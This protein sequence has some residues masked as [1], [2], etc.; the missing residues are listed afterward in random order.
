MGFK[1]V[2]P[3]VPKKGTPRAVVSQSH[4]QACYGIFNCVSWLGRHAH[5]E[6]KKTGEEGYLLEFVMSIG[7]AK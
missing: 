1:E 4:S 7:G 2:T 3:S 5:K 6:T